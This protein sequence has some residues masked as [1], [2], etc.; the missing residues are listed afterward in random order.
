MLLLGSLYAQGASL[1]LASGSGVK[2]SSVSLNLSLSGA[3]NAPTGLQW[4][5]S[6]PPSDITSLG[7]IAGPVLTAAGKTLNCVAGTGSLTCLAT[8]MNVSTIGSGVVAVV[9]AT[10]SATSNNSPDAIVMTNAM[11]VLPDGS[12]MTV[13]GTG[14]TITVGTTVSALQCTPTT[15]V[16]GGTSTCTVTL[17]K[18]AAS[19]TAV[20]L[21]DNSGALTVPASV[22][23]TT[24]ATTANFTATAGA[25]T[26]NQTATV[27]ASLNSSS[28]TASL[29]ITPPAAGTISALQCAPTTVVSG[30]TST[31]TVTLSKAATSSTAVGLSDNSGALTVP[32]SVTV[33]A[34]AT[35]AN[36]TATAGT[37]TANQT[38]TVTASLGG[39]SKTASLNIQ[40]PTQSSLIAAY[41]FDENSGSTT[42]DASGNSNTGQIKGATWTASAKHGKALSFNGS[43]SYIDLG[44]SATLQSSGSMTWSAWIYATGNP[45]DDGQIIARSDN[46]TGWQ[47]KTT[48]DTGKRT[49]G[50][51]VSGSSSG[52]TQRYSKT[53]YSLNTWYYVAGVYNTG[54]KTLD[55]YVNGVLDN[56]TLTGTIP[57]SQVNPALNATIGERSGGYYFKGVIDDVRVYN[58]PLSVAEIQNDMNTAVSASGSVTGNSISEETLAADST[59]VRASSA[60]LKATSSLSCSPKTVNA[61][62]RVTCELRAASKLASPISL[63]SSSNLVTVPAVV[64]MR[65]NQTR[66]AFQVF[67]DP[68]AKQEAATLTATLEDTSVEESILVAPSSTP[69]LTVPGKQFAK[70]G[71][72]LSFQVA[73]ADSSGLP[74]QLTAADVPPDAVFDP[75]SGQFKWT[76]GTTQAGRHQITF[77]AVNMAGQASTAQVDIDVDSGKPVLNAVEKFACSSGAI[78]TLNGKWLVES[79]SSFSDPSGNSLE[80]GGSSVKINGA[81]V[82]VLSVSRTRVHFLCPALESGSPLSATLE[83]ASGTSNALSATMQEVSPEIFSVDGSGEN[84]GVISFPNAAAMATPRS[85][86]IPGYPAQPGDQILIWGT[87]FGSTTESANKAASVTLGGVRA[88]VGSVRAV[89]GHMGLYTVEVRVPE[90]AGFGDAVPVQ[91]MVTTLDG[92]QFA[93][94]VVTMATESGQ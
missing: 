7:A 70:F 40:A 62:G 85:P 28:K 63:A 5:L 91:L 41:A 20:G 42:T 77:K 61:G 17:S 11:G 49:F 6:Y 82:P 25:V 60:L 89:P 72:S 51:A 15:V 66:L 50:I 8:G 14:G 37:V 43:S 73:G 52:H 33:A 1:S 74:V 79:E 48:P 47:L 84:E 94:N 81:S 26:A 64:E 65:R 69:I 59:G 35:T 75:G 18:A 78:A 58:R 53:V 39:S 76:P 23:V 30:G 3:T 56:G 34:N 90:T 46:S 54:T 32:A 21:S 44:K 27:T 2:G 38:A 71:T 29:T 36:F 4:K 93:S 22:T 67:V 92:K 55:I 31:C 57:G 13:S 16:S 87:G 68:M 12:N 19:S 24:G 83:T 80:L 86:R 9:T 45:P 88:G 10:I